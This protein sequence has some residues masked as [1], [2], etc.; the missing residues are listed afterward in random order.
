MPYHVFQG[1]RRRRRR[2]RP[3]RLAML[4][5]IACGAAAASLLTSER[6]PAPP[7]P[8]VQTPESRL[9]DGAP[10]PLAGGGTAPSPL[11]VRL[12]DPRDLVRVRFKHPP[13]WA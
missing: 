5:V 12:D 7:Q 9:A 10:A 4:A 1:G 2:R 3:A 13:R 6:D 8:A 11:S